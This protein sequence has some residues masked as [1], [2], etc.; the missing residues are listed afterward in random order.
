MQMDPDQLAR[1]LRD[2]DPTFPT[3]DC[4]ALDL[5]ECHPDDPK[6]ITDISIRWVQLDDDPELEAILITK[7]ESTYMAYV[8]DKQGTAWNMV[9]SLSCYRACDA[10]RFIRVQKLTEDS[11]TLLLCY[12]DLGGMGS[13]LMTTEAFQLR[14][15][16]LWRV[17]EID[18]FSDVLFPSE[19]IRTQSVLASRDRLVIH[20]IREQPP[21]HRVRSSC[22][23]WRWETSKHTFV[24]F[25]AERLKYCDPQT[26]NPI[27]GKAFPTPF[28][29]HP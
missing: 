12:R 25:P 13:T 29:I 14:R 9:G 21:G 18:D 8:F 1:G 19:V 10:N 20:T 4:Q 17:F 22:D 2:K 6:R 28:P 5:W 24:Q 23:V 11:P 16:K 15:G 3:G 26:G 27:A 7:E